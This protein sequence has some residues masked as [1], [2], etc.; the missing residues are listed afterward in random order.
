[1]IPRQNILPFSKNNSYLKVGKFIKVTIFHELMLSIQRS[2]G[3]KGQ[4]V[5]PKD[6]R[7]QFNLNPGSQVVFSVRDDEIVIKPAVDP[8]TFVEE[9]IQGGKGLKLMSV[10]EMKKIL[11]EEY[12][13]R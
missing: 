12:E 2:I 13:Q 6:I 4:I 8:V 11:E 3:P 7:K 9:F 5:L 1:M 10:K